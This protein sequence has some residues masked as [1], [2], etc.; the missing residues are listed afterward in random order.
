[1]P[2]KRL[3]NCLSKHPFSQTCLPQ[4]SSTGSV[5]A[6]GASATS[7]SSSKAMRWTAEMTRVSS[8][9]GCKRVCV[10]WRGRALPFL[11]E[12]STGDDRLMDISLHK[13]GKYDQIEILRY[14]FALVEGKMGRFPTLRTL[15]LVE[16]T[17]CSI[18]VLVVFSSCNCQ[19]LT[20]QKLPLAVLVC[21]SMWPPM[22]KCIKHIWRC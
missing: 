19:I 8:I 6:T 15:W 12:V 7:S 10:P 17:I 2:D 22:Q 13:H 4:A 18:S 21:F 11:V 14:R 5:G 20:W 9:S 16:V 3:D 1:M